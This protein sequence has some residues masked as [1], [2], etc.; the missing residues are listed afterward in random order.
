MSRYRH[1]LPQLAVAPLLTDG[2]LETTLVYHHGY[3]LP[4]F[5]A[6]HLLAD[7][8]GTEVMRQYFLRYAAIAATRGTGF[9]LESPT[10]RA[11]PDWGT[12][13]G[14]DHTRLMEANRAAIA[15]MTE[16]RERYDDDQTPFVISGNLGPRADGYVPDARMSHAEARDYHA[17]QIDVFAGTEADLVTA[18]TL[19]YVEEA[20]GIVDAARAAGL[21]AAISFTVETDGRLPTGEPLGEAI[22][23]T[24]ELTDGHAAYYMINCA[25]PTHFEGV[26]GDPVVARRLRGVRA[27]ASRSS[28]A[29]LDASTE[30]DDGDPDELG[31]EYRA[32]RE[33]LPALSVLGGCCGTDHRHVAAIADYCL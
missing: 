2:G 16:V 4:C 8:A 33:R 10:W 31:R 20:A 28:H 7:E 3:E 17:F 30:L 18:L 14:Y 13:L 22:R 23:R 12:R 29:E 25:H 24:D 6:F 26:T 32:L 11:S 9:V 19:N 15:L 27:N 5:A 1:Q 21:P